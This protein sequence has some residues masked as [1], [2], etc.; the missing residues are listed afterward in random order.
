VRSP[1]LPTPSGE[2]GTPWGDVEVDGRLYKMRS[3]GCEDAF[4]LDAW[5]LQILGEAAA[6]AIASGLEG[7][8]PALILSAVEKFDGLETMA[9]V[10]AEVA[11]MLEGNIGNIE[12][13]EYIGRMAMAV[14]PKVADLVREVL[15]TALA[16]VDARV[17]KDMVR[18]TMFG[19]TLQAQDPNGVWFPVD[20]FNTLD[21]ALNQI[22]NGPRRQM[23]KWRLLHRAIQCTWGP[24]GPADPMHPGDERADQTGQPLH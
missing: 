2:L 10:R 15:P 22:P 16:K 14:A 4:G 11:E 12:T 19:G 17:V 21:H 13:V 24:F 9:E 3:L 18:L 23:H 6:A 1:R 7:I 8:L 20:S 5:L